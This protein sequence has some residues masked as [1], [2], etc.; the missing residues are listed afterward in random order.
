MK[1]PYC[2]LFLATH[3][4]G[5]IWL[6]T[7]LLSILSG[8]PSSNAGKTLDRGIYLPPARHRISLLSHSSMLLGLIF[9][10]SCSG[11]TG[12]TGMSV[13]PLNFL[14]RFYRKRQTH[15][16]WLNSGLTLTFKSAKQEHHSAFEGWLSGSAQGSSLREREWLRTDAFCKDLRAKCTLPFHAPY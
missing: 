10:E 15:R 14:Q 6:M 16:T 3:N 8:T 12:M 5:T 2:Q 11:M 13:N 4:S 9:L 1:L 7:S